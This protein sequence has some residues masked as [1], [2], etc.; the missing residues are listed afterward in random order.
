[1]ATVGHS[2]VWRQRTF[3]DSEWFAFQYQRLQKQRKTDLRVR[4]VSSPKLFSQNYFRLLPDDLGRSGAKR[5]A[6]PQKR[7]TARD[8]PP[9][10]RL[11]AEIE[12]GDRGSALRRL[13]IALAS[14][15]VRFA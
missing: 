4:R 2:L 11:M 1:V 13:A 5:V 8:L 9:R 12:E 3:S 15:L 6:A 10:H 14:P 7:K